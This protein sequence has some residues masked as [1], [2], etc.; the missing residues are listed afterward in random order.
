MRVA[1]CTSQAATRHRLRLC[2]LSKPAQAGFEPQA[3][4]P[5]GPLRLRS[6]KY[7]KRTTRPAALAGEEALLPIVEIGLHG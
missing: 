4:A 7:K 6:G 5:R 1:L 2:R 3:P